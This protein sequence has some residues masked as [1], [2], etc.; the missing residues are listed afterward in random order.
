MV[1]IIVVSYIIIYI[2]RTSWTLS[3]PTVLICCGFYTSEP[4]IQS[5]STAILKPIIFSVHFCSQ[6]VSYRSSHDLLVFLWT[7]DCHSCPNLYNYTCLYCFLLFIL[8][9]KETDRVRGRVKLERCSYKYHPDYNNQSSEMYK[10]L[11]NDF[12][13]NVSCLKFAFQ[14]NIWKVL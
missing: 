7:L 9:T 6:R 1:I 14:V 4:V 2:T 8:V 5:P 12:I 13:K 10:E 11:S 3:V